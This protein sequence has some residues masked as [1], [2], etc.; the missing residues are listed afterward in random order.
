M[1]RAESAS[2]ATTRL[3]DWY[4]NLI[5]IERRPVVLAVSEKT[6]LPVLVPRAPAETFT[7]QF[8]NGVAEV[9]TALHVHEEAIDGEVGAMT[10]VGVAATNDRA[11]VGTLVDFARMLEMYEGEDRTLRTLALDLAETPC[12]VLKGR[13]PRRATIEFFERS[14]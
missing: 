2:H 14:R 8:Q 9:L 6:L 1:A 3:G 11:I 7:M 10:D 5:Y 12:S 4:A 13:S